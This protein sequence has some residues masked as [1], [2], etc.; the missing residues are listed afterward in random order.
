MEEAP[1]PFTT[2]GDQVKKELINLESENGRKV[3]AKICQYKY[4]KSL[5][6]IM[7]FEDDLTRTKYKLIYTLEEL[8]SLHKIFRASDN[9]SEALDLI[10]DSFDSKN[11]KIKEENGNICLKMNIIVGRKENKFQF[12]LLKQSDDIENIVNT[13]NIKV[14]QIE[15]EIDDIKKNNNINQQ[16][17]NKINAIEKNQQDINKK[18]D[19][20]NKKFDQ[21]NKRFEKIES[22]IFVDSNL[23]LGK[24]FK[25]NDEKNLI[26]NAIKQRTKKEPISTKLLFSTSIDG[27]KSSTFHQKC[28]NIKNTLVITKANGK[29]FGGFT[30]QIWNKTDSYKEDKM[31]FLFSLDNMEIY[32]YKNDGKAIFCYGDF[33]PI[34]GGGCDLVICDN[35][36]SNKNSSAFSEISYDF[37]GKNLVLSGTKES[38]LIEEYNI[39]EIKFQE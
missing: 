26:K 37:K 39:Y 38:F 17:L 29:R 35:C 13:V 23:D 19:N 36:L 22:K 14:Q 8:Q 7:F 9:I 24:L 18:I 34:F 25:N 31:A 4:S 27:D 28:D 15:K 33:G 11:Y 1:G 3:K 20:I 32:N 5:E 6:I 2:P 30:S 10:K 21:I 16:I 12:I